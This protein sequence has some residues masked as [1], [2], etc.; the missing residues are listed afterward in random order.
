[1]RIHYT[2]YHITGNAGHQIPFEQGELEVPENGHGI[3][4][5][6]RR[7]FPTFDISRQT[8]GSEDFRMHNADWTTGIA[9]TV[10]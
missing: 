3:R 9:I 1:M 5:N 8:V 4:Y 10:R 6:L 7:M 2:M